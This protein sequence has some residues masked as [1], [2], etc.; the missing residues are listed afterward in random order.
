[1]KLRII[2][3][4][5]SLTLFG[6]GQSQDAAGPGDEAARDAGAVAASRIFDM[7]YLMRELEN[8]LRVI[9]VKTDYPDIVTL[10]IP[11]QTGSR[12]EV[13]PGKS[14][15]AHFFEHMMYRGTEKYPSEAYAAILKKAGASKN[16]STTD[17]FTNFHITFT[18]PDLETMIEI[19]ADRFQNLAYSE[20]DFRT[21]ALAINGEYLKNYSNPIMKAFER[22]RALEFTVHPYSHTTMGFVEDIEAMPDQIEYS[23]EFFDRW[24]RPENTAVIVVGDVDP[25]AT[26][27]LIEQHR[28]GRTRL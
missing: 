23:R 20:A 21:E 18:K 8:G 1:M 5:V 19:E 13:E 28:T 4:I 2:G 9:V 25:E 11:V 26:F 3:A 7:P 14:G 12:N 24:Y 10:Q 27:D 17:D 6:C 15:F 16:A 22:T